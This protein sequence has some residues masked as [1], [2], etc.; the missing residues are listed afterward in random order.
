PGRGTAGLPR[1]RSSGGTHLRHPVRGRTQAGAHRPGAD[2]RSGAAAARRTGGGTGSGRAR[3]PGGAAGRTGRRP[4]RPGHGA[5]DPPRRGDSARLHPRAAAQPGPRG[6]AGT[7]RPGDHRREPLDRLRPADRTAARGRTFLRPAGCGG[8]DLMP[9]DP[10][11]RA[12][13]PVRDAATVMLLRDGVGGIEVFLLRRVTGMDFAG[14]M[15]VFP[16]GG[17]DPG[18]GARIGW[19]G[20][21]PQWW[22]QRWGTDEGRARALVTAA[23]RETFEECGVL[24]AGDTPGEVVADARRYGDQRVE[25]ESHRM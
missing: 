10:V 1:C 13:V 20:P 5:G 7:D 23:V 12:D 16:G 3:G 11:G 2:D 15:T 14:G 9:L 8:T 24:L 21:D 25:I 18:E 4:R 6:G 19:A 22:A 17:V